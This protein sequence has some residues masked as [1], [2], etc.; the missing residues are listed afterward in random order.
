MYVTYSLETSQT[1]FVDI[2]CGQQ[3]HCPRYCQDEHF[4][5]MYCTPICRAE[6]S[7]STCN[8]GLKPP[9]TPKYTGY[10]FWPQNSSSFQLVNKDDWYSNTVY[11]GQ[12]FGKHFTDTLTFPSD[13]D[14]TANL[15][16]QNVE[17]IDGLLLED[18]FFDWS[19]GVVGLAPGDGNIVTQLY[20]QN[21]IPMPTALLVIGHVGYTGVLGFGIDVDGFDVCDQHYIQRPT[22]NSNYWVFELE[23]FEL[24]GLSYGKKTKALLSDNDN[25]I[26]LLSKFMRR[27]VDLKVISIYDGPEV[28][29][30]AYI[31]PCDQL[32]EL[33]LTVDGQNLTVSK[34]AL[35]WKPIG[36]NTCLSFL[37][38]LEHPHYLTNVD[39][40]L[41]ISFLSEFC[42]SFDYE[43]MTMSFAKRI[44]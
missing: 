41:G 32:F 36:N 30:H 21:L 19:G 16:I 27:L 6:I 11:F 24:N 9:I 38:P 12:Q 25:W 28:D 33:T 44:L 40:V 10:H 8:Q 42:V 29:N 17:M 13:G 31:F 2:D 15:T 22:M 5:K 20:A 7:K 34:S 43:Q 23:D 4:K 14:Y 37:G 18:Y 26:Y 39:M 35:T 3:P 1:V